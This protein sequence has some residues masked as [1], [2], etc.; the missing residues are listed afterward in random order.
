MATQDVAMPPGGRPRIARHARGALKFAAPAILGLI[1][2]VPIVAWGDEP[3]PAI[4]SGQR[5]ISRGGGLPCATTTAWWPASATGTR[6][7][8]SSGSMEPGCGSAP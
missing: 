7:T 8:G 2:L 3:S 5:V 4:R 6:S 1:V